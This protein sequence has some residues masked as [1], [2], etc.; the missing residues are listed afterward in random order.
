MAK[1]KTTAK[2]TT[3]EKPLTPK[4]ERFC[5]EYL[6]DLNAKQAAIRAGYSAKTAHS[7]GAENLTKPEVEKRV[8]E[9]RLE[10]SNKTNVTKE[11]VIEEYAKIAFFDIREIYDVDGG[12]INVKQI[13]DKSA[14]A[15]ASIKA[16]EEWGEDEEGNKTIV[17]TIKE[18]KIFDKIRALQD[19]GKH[20]GLFEKDNE[21]KQASSVVTIF[22]LPDNGRK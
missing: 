7:I 8:T 10:L 9:L 18:V 1:Q 20:L 16:T 2:R 22:E 4:Q 6:V 17:G 14:G 19:L 15:I 3:A 12:L 11:R 13:D 21:Q 5:Q